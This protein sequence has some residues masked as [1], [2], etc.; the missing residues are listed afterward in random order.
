MKLYDFYRRFSALPQEKRNV[1]LVD[2]RHDPMTPMIIFK[3]LE[4]ARQMQTFYT[5]RVEELL[6]IAEETFNQVEGTSK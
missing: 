4:Y 2:I 3:Q 5:S 6:R 1:L